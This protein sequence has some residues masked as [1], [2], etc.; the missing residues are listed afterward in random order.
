MLC[1]PL[2]LFGTCT[3]PSSIWALDTVPSNSFEWCFFLIK[4]I[5]SNAYTDCYSANHLRKTL[6]ISRIFSLLSFLF[7]YFVMWTPASRF[8]W[9]HFSLFQL[10]QI[11]LVLSPLSLLLGNSH[12][13]NLGNH[14]AN[15]NCLVLCMFRY[16]GVTQHRSFSNWLFFYSII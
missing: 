15:F 7:Q 9:T 11:C 10:S 5:S 14:M 16:N 13:S 1:F 4:V 12:G 6:L 2:W 8:P 3:L